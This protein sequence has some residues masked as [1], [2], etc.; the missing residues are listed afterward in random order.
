[1]KRIAFCMALLMG[2]L[3]LYSSCGSSKSATQDNS[4]YNN[5]KAQVQQPEAKKR[6]TRKVDELAAKA[7]TNLRA[8][9]MGND[10][11]EKYARSEALRNGLATLASELQSS[12]VALTQEYHKKGV[13]NQKKIAETS[14]EG[15][16][17]T[18]VS[19][20]VSTK[21]IG[22]P[23]V[24]DLSDGTVS[25][26]VCVELVKPTDE[27]IGDVYDELTR[28]EV[29]GIDYDKQKF[30]KDNRERLEELRNQVK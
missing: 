20:K 13:I 17:E 19:Q 10:F 26:Y 23:E 8:V 27:V 22:V 1:M 15:M 6:E 16:V 7:T 30:I 29:I 24:Y 4:Y 11:D 3:S 12:I 25:V 14:I 28:D 5:P 2:S 21:L 18:A 9:G